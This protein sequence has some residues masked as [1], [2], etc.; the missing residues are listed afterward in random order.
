MI[1]DNDMKGFS[2]PNPKTVILANAIRGEMSRKPANL[3]VVGCGSGIE[4]ATLACELNCPVIGIDIQTNFDPEA[5]KF[6]MLKQGDATRLEFQDGE[7]DVVY[8]FHA[9]EHIHDDRLAV[10]EMKRVLKPDGLLCIGTPNRSRLIG[11]LGSQGVGWVTKFWWNFI[12]WKARL[13]GRFR[14]EFGAHAGYTEDE[15]RTIL[16]RS[17]NDVRSITDNYYFSLYSSQRTL[18][19]ILKKSG[20][21]RLLFPSIYFLCR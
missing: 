1:G 18:I 15:L 16:V 2:H 21:S 12:D 9:L 7:F 4:A 14:N 10:S 11:Y 5:M 3:L 19:G 20:M 6:A 17:F 8:S 13:L